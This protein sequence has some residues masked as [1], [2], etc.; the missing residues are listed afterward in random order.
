MG[1]GIYFGKRVWQTEG[2]AIPP[3]NKQHRYTEFTDQDKI[4]ND[5]LLRPDAGTGRAAA[6]ARKRLRAQV[7]R[8]P[9]TMAALRRELKRWGHLP[10]PKC[11]YAP[12]R[13][14]FK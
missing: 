12:A 1:G 4:E 10:G 6:L 8:R 11:P 2:P 14:P 5:E 7:D 3:D 13:P 9:D